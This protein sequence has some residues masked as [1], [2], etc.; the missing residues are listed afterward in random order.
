M[1]R[2]IESRQDVFNLVDKFYKKIRADEMLGPIFNRAISD[3]PEHLEKLTDFWESQL[4]FTKRFRGNPQQAHI[5]IDAREG[6]SI[7]NAHFGHWMNIWFETAD[8]LYKGEITERA[9]H[10]ARKMSTFLYLKIWE[11]RPNKDS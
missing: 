4:L 6:H 5:D 2:D 10:N 1:D 8:E 11:A 9:K 3:W 7:S